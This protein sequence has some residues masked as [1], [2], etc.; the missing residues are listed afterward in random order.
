MLPLTAAKF[1]RFT[2]SKAV[3]STTA[4]FGCGVLLAQPARSTEKPR[5]DSLISLTLGFYVIHSY[6][7]LIGF[8]NF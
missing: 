1:G 8:V 3:V 7:Y 2:E 5:E 6:I 4:A